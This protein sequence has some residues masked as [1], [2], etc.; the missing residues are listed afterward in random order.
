MA[1]VISK[2]KQAL[3]KKISKQTENFFTATL[4]QEGR[5]GNFRRKVGKCLVN[6]TAQPLNP[7]QYFNLFSIKNFAQNTGLR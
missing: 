6:P 5:G 3:L 4:N 1:D 7:N 2:I